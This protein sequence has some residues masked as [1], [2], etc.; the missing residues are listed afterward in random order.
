[1]RKSLY[2]YLIAAALSACDGSTSESNT[3]DPG[4]LS[5]ECTQFLDG[6]EKYV[7]DYIQLL[8][9]YKSNPT[10]L[11]LMQRATHM[12]EE[13]KTWSDNAAPGCKDVAAFMSRQMKIQAKLTRA[14]F[15]L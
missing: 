3:E 8:K 15:T 9:D 10:D 5:P 12:A 4:E 11:S 2:F 1:M 13:A 7:D 14:S 6:Y